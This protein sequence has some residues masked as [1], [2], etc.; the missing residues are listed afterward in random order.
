MLPWMFKNKI[1]F[2]TFKRTNI[3]N[4]NKRK[5]RG[6]FYW[7]H[8]RN[9][10]GFLNFL[11]DRSFKNEDYNYVS[12]KNIAELIIPEKFSFYDN[13]EGS[14]KVLQQLVGMYSDHRIEEIHIDHSLC[15]EIDLAASMMMDAILW[16]IDIRRKKMGKKIVFSGTL[17]HEENNK[18]NENILELLACSGVLKHLGV[19]KNLKIPEHIETLDFY[20]DY[21]KSEKNI[22]HK[23][24]GQKV[25]EYFNRCY[26]KCGFSLTK[27]GFNKLSDLVAEIVLNCENH[28]GENPK[29]WFCQGHYFVNT[30]DSNRIGECQLSIV[31]IG[32]SFFEGIN[33]GTEFIQDKCSEQYDKINSNWKTWF[34]LSKE[35]K[36]KELFYLLF[37]LQENVS[38]LKDDNKNSD[39]GKGT[40]TLFENFQDIGKTSEGKNP[41]L[42]ITSGSAQIL[43][44]GTYKM[45]SNEFGTKVIAFNKENDINLKPDSVYVHNI[46]S[47]FPGVIINLKFYIDEHY[48]EEYMNNKR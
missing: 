39:R 28:C 26:N 46:N 2:L 9:Y 10:H 12:S 36:K 13:P 21:I 32:Q 37:C 22:D 15:K 45:Q 17:K 47:F 5:Y 18:E 11:N 1:E 30:K 38:R 44:D 3:R 20:D 48:L 34:R 7:K 24:A 41:L 35:K 42:S 40:V 25:T 4:R 14:L 19:I 29:R 31:S 16:E 27:D 43:F 23:L 8:D 33:T 6:K